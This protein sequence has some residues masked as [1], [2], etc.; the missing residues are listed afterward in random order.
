MILFDKPENLPKIDG[1][2]KIHFKWW[3]DHPERYN[4][5]NYNLA[6]DGKVVGSVMIKPFSDKDW[7]LWSGVKLTRLFVKGIHH[8]KYA[9]EL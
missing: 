2:F 3:S 4:S 9:S 1:R 5:V 8:W 6:I 7:Y